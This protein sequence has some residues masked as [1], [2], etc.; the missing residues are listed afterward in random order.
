MLFFQS[1][2]LFIGRHRQFSSG[3]TLPLG[4]NL[5][6]AMPKA[7]FDNLK[8]DWGYYQKLLTVQ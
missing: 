8:L 7:S 2:S 5:G 1:M 4:R 3:S 6:N